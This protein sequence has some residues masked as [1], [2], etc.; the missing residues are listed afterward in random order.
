MNPEVESPQSHKLTSKAERSASRARRFGAGLLAVAI[1][2]AGFLVFPQQASAARAG[3]TSNRSVSVSLSCTSSSVSLGSTTTCTGSV[4]DTESGGTKTVPRGTVALTV[5][6]GRIGVLTACTLVNSATANQSECSF[7][8]INLSNGNGEPA[9]KLTYTP[10]ADDIHQTKSKEI[11]LN[12]SGSTF[13]QHSESSLSAGKPGASLKVFTVGC[14]SS[15][16][17]YVGAFVST[18]GDPATANR[19]STKVWETNP[20]TDGSHVFD[21]ALEADHPTGTFYVRFFCADASPSSY[22][23]DAMKKTSSLYTYVVS[24]AAVAGAP[25]PLLCLLCML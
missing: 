25:A 4:R 5:D 3:A 9:L 1:A 14:A 18:A 2:A 11:D 10:A 20:S 19:V 6:S 7:K 16:A 15:S 24:A 12:F 21:T 23:S 8:I 13:K 17:R 22:S